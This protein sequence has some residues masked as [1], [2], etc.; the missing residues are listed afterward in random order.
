MM[1][2]VHEPFSHRERTD[3]RVKVRLRY[4][5]SDD[6]P[7]FNCI[8]TSQ[9]YTLFFFLFDLRLPRATSVEYQ[10]YN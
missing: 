4:D 6:F 3:M 8:F 10:I 9:K 1:L 5:F 2:R 7:D